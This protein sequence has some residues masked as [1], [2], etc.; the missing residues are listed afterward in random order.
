[1]V[2][3]V[4]RRAAARGDQPKRPTR[5]RGL[6]HRGAGELARR[7]RCLRA[8]GPARS[9]RGHGRGSADRK[10][11]RRPR[12]RLDRVRL[13]RARVSAAPVHRGSG[14]APRALPQ[15][16]R[17]A[18]VDD[19]LRPGARGARRRRIAGAAAGP[20]PGRTGGVRRRRRDRHRRLPAGLYRRG[21]AH[22]RRGVARCARPADLRAAA[23]RARRA[24]TRH[25]RLVYRA[26][27]AVRQRRE[28][29]DG[30]RRGGQRSSAPG[31]GPRA[32]LPHE[33]DAPRPR[34]GEGADARQARRQHPPHQV[35]DRSR[36]RARRERAQRARPAAAS[37]QGRP[38]AE[39]E[40]GVRRTDRTTHGAAAHATR[41]GRRPGAAEPR[42][43]VPAPGG[44]GR[45]RSPAGAARDPRVESLWI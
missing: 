18:T 11:Y 21:R 24:G 31:S 41:D 27:T 13:S 16:D 40:S 17:P 20:L 3:R 34:R 19:H 5:R 9:R 42:A 35:P 8:W 37:G 23:E 44:R 28:V 10:P 26:R 30:R 43:V 38:V 6:P 39:R 45:H 22:R 1:M 33:H 14:R 36:P 15:G 4:A 12:P 29:P 2:C 32:R 25:A 7:P